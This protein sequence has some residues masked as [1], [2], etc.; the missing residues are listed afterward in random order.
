M[1]SRPV[2]LVLCALS[3]GLS[4]CSATAH[5]DVSLKEVPV[6]H[7]PGLDIDT[8][9][10]ED[11]ERDALGMAPRYAVPNPVTITPQTHGRWTKIDKKTAIWRLRF[12]CK[13][14]ISMNF[15]FSRWL[16]PIDGEMRI[17]NMERTHRIRPFDVNDIQPTGELWTPP[18]AGN[19]VLI[20]IS[21]PI[22]ARWLIEQEIEL[23]SVNPGYRGFHENF[24]Q[25][26][27]NTG[28][29][30]SGSC[31]VDVVCPQSAGWE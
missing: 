9:A 12:S 17:S 29:A 31:N 26:A 19:D 30:F 28:P 7:L 3:F 4:F 20:E 6:I 13:N 18:V 22:E 23:S 8:L 14:A 21:C 1:F 2:V 11:E 10:I 15:G 16:V 5:A 24:G 25:T 27:T